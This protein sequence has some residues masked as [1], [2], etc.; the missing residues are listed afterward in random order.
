MRDASFRKIPRCV[1]ACRGFFC[2]T[3]TWENME[4]NGKSLGKMFESKT[5]AFE[6]FPNDVMADGIKFYN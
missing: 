5:N 2:F 4:R 1:S 3:A 6:K